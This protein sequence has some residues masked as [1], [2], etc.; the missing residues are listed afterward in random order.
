MKIYEQIMHHLDLLDGL[1]R[2][3]RSLLLSAQKNR[4]DLVEEITNNRDRLVS[5]I[6]TIQSGIEDEI[7]KLIPGKVCT[8]D[9][10]I[11][12]TWGREVNDLI[13]LND[14]IDLACLEILEKEK[15]ETTKEIATVFR[16]NQSVKGYNLNSVKK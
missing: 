5:I 11:I 2:A 16:A 9:I 1:T 4:L 10:N 12:K 8:D 15:E 13:F 3:S 6:K 7:S 14:Q